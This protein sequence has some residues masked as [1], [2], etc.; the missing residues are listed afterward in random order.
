MSLIHRLGL[1]VVVLGLAA[2]CGDN[3]GVGIDGGGDGNPDDPDA[4][5]GGPAISA[6]ESV[7]MP[8]PGFTGGRAREADMAFSGTQYLVVWRDARLGYSTDIWGAR[9]NPDGTLVDPSGFAIASTPS[10]EGTPVVARN[11][12][13]WIVAWTLDEDEG[14]AAA[15][16]SDSAL[17]TP[18]GTVA[19]TAAVENNIDLAAN[20]TSALLVWQSDN[21]V[22]GAVYSAGSFGAAFPIAATA[23]DEANPGVASSTGDF[24]VAFE[25]GAT[26]QDLRAQL[27]TAAGTLSGSAFTVS[28]TTGAQIEPAGTFD[29]TNFVLTWKGASDVW[30]A[31]IS[32]TG[33]VLDM[34]AGGI[35]GV[36]I[37]NSAN[38]VNG[39]A[40]ACDATTCLFG[41]D[42]RTDLVNNTT[43]VFGQRRAVAD[44]TAVG[45]V[46]TI[47]DD[48]R[49]QA[50]ISLAPRTG[51]GH[52]A[53]WDDREVG[54]HNISLARIDSTGTVEDP[55]GLLVN[56]GAMNSHRN[57]V[58]TTSASG[59]LAAW[60]DSRA[61]GSD[62]MARR[63]SA[64]GEQLDGNP[65]A[66]TVSDATYEQRATAIA[67]SG[68]QYL[69]A[70]SDARNPTFDLF[71]ARFLDDGTN[72]DPAG[73]PISVAPNNQLAP[74][75]ASNGSVFMIAFHD[76]SVGGNDI[77]GAIVTST[78][79]VTR[80]DI[81]RAAMTQ[82]NPT[83]AWDPAGSVF[84]VAWEDQRS[85]TDIDIWAARVQ[86]D[87]TVLDTS[88]VLVSGGA[89][90]ERLPAIEA[91]GGQLLVVWE[92][93]VADANGDIRGARLTATGA[94][95]VLDATGIAIAT[96]A[97]PQQLP[98][99]GALN[100]GRWSVAWEDHGIV[101]TEGA[102][103][104]GNEVLSTGI[105]AYA[106]Y[107]IANSTDWETGPQFQTGNNDSA[108]TYIVY[109]Q[110]LP[111]IQAPIAMRRRL[112]H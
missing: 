69:V 96:G 46:I 14:V 5:T 66:R 98:T 104:F 80:F 59:Q 29:G 93:L 106:G 78:G 79:T 61:F 54:I 12:T 70:W 3:I 17:V 40:V 68:T 105:L 110:T 21:D 49:H 4:A 67:S 108:T 10:D 44:F 43:D 63:Y 77:A 101:A 26:A 58:F 90:D 30:G 74:D 84:V 82:Q 64:T 22:R 42:E 53:V 23:A 33:T 65:G 109:S 28:A 45:G 19:G 7:E 13:Q 2:S 56:T 103:I 41:W 100:N 112:T 86:P 36:R 48:L 20:G 24:L 34:S 6:P 89:G 35:G 51:G 111:G 72:L 76:Q 47:N 32:P 18:L 99:V 81:S 73:I 55:A 83:I 60:S 25:E 97:A 38:L 15:V 37:F 62:I 85:G 94:L 11:G 9:V 50:G 107:I 71:A 39:L 1:M 27:V 57:A 88:G 91:A 75:I 87:G 102:N 8:I 95:T 16:V 92:D 31:R 52:I